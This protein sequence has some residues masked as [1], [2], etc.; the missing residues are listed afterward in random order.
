[1]LKIKVEGYQEAKAILDEL[2]NNMQKKMLRSALK[3]SSKPFV[4]GAQSRVPVK[5]G[6]L[7]KQLKV[8][9]FR[10]KSAPKSE[11]DVAVK[12]VF[13]RSK[14][15]KAV[16]EYY[17]KFVHEGTADPRYPKKKGGV[18][19]FTLPN[20]DKVFARHV[21]GL[22]PRPYIEESY[23][24]NYEKVV[25]SFGDELGTAVEKFVNR[26]FKKVEK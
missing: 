9:S 24:E 15:K 13:S 7:K 16:N 22:K 4:K 2:P 18:L 1:M 10:D 20:G 19:V 8:V 11:V 17:G 12:H 6:T 3:S 25:S 5:S 21:K 26:N 14:K 23:Q